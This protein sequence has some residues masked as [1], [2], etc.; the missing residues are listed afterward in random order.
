MTTFDAPTFADLGVSPR[1][2]AALEAADIVTPLPDPGP[3][4]PRRP[5]RARRLRQ[6]QDRLGQDPRLRPPPPHDGPQGQAGPAHRPD[7]RPHPRAGRPGARRA[8][9][10]RPGRRPLGHRRLRRHAHGA[11]DQGRSRKGYDVVVATPGRLIDL[12]P[13]GATSPSPTCDV[14]VL[15]EADRMADM[16]FMPQVDVAPATASPT[17]HQTMLF[18]ATLDCDDRPPGAHLHQRPGPPRGRV[19]P[20]DGRGDGAPLPQGPRARQGEGGGGHRQG[21]RAA[22]WSSAAPSGAPTAWTIQLRAGGRQGR[23][24]PRRPGPERP[25]AGPR[26]TSARTTL[27][28]LVATDVAARGLDVD[29][30]DVVVHYDPP[31]DHTAYLHRSGRTARA[32]A[33]GVAVSLLL[34]DQVL[35]SEKLRRRLGIRQPVVELFSNDAR[36]TRPAVGR[37]GARCPRRPPAPTAS[38]ARAARRPSPPPR[39]APAPCAPWAPAAA[40]ARPPE[41][42]ELVTR[43]RCARSLDAATRWRHQLRVERGSGGAVAALD[44]AAVGHRQHRLAQ[45]HRAG[46]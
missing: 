31:E 5:R 46:A 24:P 11:P 6:G 7:P 15:D 26:A 20:A 34:W 36:L 18:S 32:G 2:V 12:V 17:E 13:T 8:G 14:L 23:R 43:H 22:P 37:V 10:P 25:P 4:H 38:T 19:D 27:G 40:G 45:A 29:G 3:H 16:G 42:S 9:A 28:V 35:E 21:R 33:T 30:I 44:A 39:P 1:L 41:P